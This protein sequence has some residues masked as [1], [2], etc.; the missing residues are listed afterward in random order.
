MTEHTQSRLRV[1]E[2]RGEYIDIKHCLND[3]PGAISLT[4]AQVVARQSWRAEAE[5]NARR[6]VACWNALE[7][8]P[9][10]DIEQLADI[11][12]VK[13]TFLC[14]EELR[15]NGRQ[16]RASLAAAHT[17]LREILA[18]DDASIVELEMMGIKTG[19]QVLA[20][21]ERIRALLAKGGV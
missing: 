11:G 9:I 2:S 16:S 14:L 1:G 3:V 4:I 12:G 17:L 8:V 10:D 15:E 5:A 20:L 13:G 7:G 18:A 6:L 21:T 19:G